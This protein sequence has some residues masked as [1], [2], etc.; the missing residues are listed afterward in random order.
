MIVRILGE[1]QLRVDDSAA[2]QLNQLDTQLEKAVEQGDEDGFRAALSALLE[3]VNASGEMF[4]SHAVL[5]GRYVLRLAVGQMS[6]TL[7]DVEQAWN[8]LRREAQELEQSG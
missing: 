5:A 4:I 6:T 7:A 2:E 1:G 8:V 3:R